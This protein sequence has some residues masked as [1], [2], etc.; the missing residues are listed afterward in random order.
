MRDS[1]GGTEAAWL[2]QPLEGGER[3]A[4]LGLGVKAGTP[5]PESK[6]LPLKSWA[7]GCWGAG[8]PPPLTCPVKEENLPGAP[9]RLLH[10][11]GL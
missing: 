8:S 3:G 9:I 6:Q 5:P 11:V 1:A 2:S 10:T 7:A 4:P